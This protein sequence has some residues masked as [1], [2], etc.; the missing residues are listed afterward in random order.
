MSKDIIYQ[1]PK[2]SCWEI[3]IDNTEGE[4]CERSDP[5]FGRLINV[6]ALE[7]VNPIVWKLQEEIER[8]KA[9]LEERDHFI[10]K[11]ELF[12]EAKIDEVKAENEKWK[13][14]YERANSHFMAMDKEIKKLQAENE[15]LKKFAENIFR[16]RRSATLGMSFDLCKSVEK[17]LKERSE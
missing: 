15:K 13:K 4:L 8:L 6:I 7:E 9:E 10:H 16:T 3:A 17:I 2:L 12:Y 11:T 5:C 1:Y 14:E